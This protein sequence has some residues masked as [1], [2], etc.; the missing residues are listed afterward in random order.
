MSLSGSGVADVLI[1]QPAVVGRVGL[2][3]TE[4]VAHPLGL[5]SKGSVWY[6]VAGTDA[7]LRTFRVWRVQSVELTDDPVRRPPGFDLAKAWEDIVARVDEQR[8]SMRVTALAGP[9]IIGR[10]RGHFGT[11]LSVKESVED[12]RIAVEIGFGNEEPAAMQ[13]AGYGLAVEVLHPA[14]LRDELAAIGTQLVKRY[15]GVSRH[16]RA[17][18]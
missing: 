4:R 16:Q 10:L 18:R 2:T 6:L 7:G 3:V 15:R 8:A 13:L 11:R 5:V 14:G 17:L 9:E 1:H 12:G